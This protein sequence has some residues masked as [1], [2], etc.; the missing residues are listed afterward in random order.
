[1]TVELKTAGYQSSQ[2]SDTAVGFKHPVTGSAT[3]MMMMPFAGDFVTLGLSRQLDRYEPALF[4]Q[5][6]E[7]P[8][9]GGDAQPRDVA[10]S[11]IKHFMW[12]Q[13]AVCFLEDLPN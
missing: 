10:L 9:Y 5:A 3:E 12:P 2:I 1:M 6:F 4:S 11:G 8:V 7:R 13:W